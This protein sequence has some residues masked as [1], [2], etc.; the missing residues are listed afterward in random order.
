MRRDVSEDFL[1]E[2]RIGMPI[3]IFLERGEYGCLFGCPEDGKDAHR[4]SLRKARMPT[5]MSF[6]DGRIGCQ[7]GSL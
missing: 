5:R 2:G 7:W 1:R 3:I 4:D 6:R